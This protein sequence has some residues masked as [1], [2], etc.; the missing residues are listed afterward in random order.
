MSVALQIR[1]VPEDVRDQLSAQ[2]RARGQSLQA[3]LLAL[4]VEQ[5][6]RQRN[7]EIL[8]RFR[9][10]SD[11]S[12]LSAGEAEELIASDRAERDSHVS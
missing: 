12:R 1:N 9:G 8:A 3:F 11:G 6:R 5:A 10:R 4:V 2:A 7:V